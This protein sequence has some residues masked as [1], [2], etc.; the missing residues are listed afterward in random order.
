MREKTNAIPTSDLNR[1]AAEKA[2]PYVPPAQRPAAQ[3]VQDFA[4]DVIAQIVLTHRD[5]KVEPQADA[6]LTTSDLLRQWH[7]RRRWRQ[8]TAR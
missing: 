1:S 4:C 6:P 8:K 3:M 2:G 7:A 5:A